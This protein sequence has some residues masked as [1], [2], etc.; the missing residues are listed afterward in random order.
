MKKQTRHFHRRAFWL[1]LL[2]LSA[3]SSLRAEP[4]LRLIQPFENQTLPYVKQSFVFGSVLPATAT[5]TI[6]GIPV[7][8]YTNG[9]FCVM[10][11]FQEGRFKIEA[12]A[13][14]G[15]S[16]TTVTR[17]VVVDGSA[18]PYP[19]DYDRIEPLYPKTRVVVRAG[20][21]IEVAFQAAPGGTA[22]FRFK[23]GDEFMPME[24][25][26]GRMPG[27]YKGSYTVRPDDKFEN[28][29]VVFLLKRRDGKKISGKLGANIILQRRRTPR[30]VELKED[31]I[32]LTGPESDYGYNLFAAPG[33]RLEVTGERGDFLRVGIGEENQG[34]IKKSVAIEMPSGAIL[35]RSVSRNMKINPGDGSTILE[36]P[37]Q[38]RHLYRVEQMIH[39]HTIK[40]T[41]F[42]VI[43]D[44]D[45]IR[46]RTPDSVI[47]EV[48][49]YQTEPTTCVIEIRTDQ[50]HPWGYDVRYEG[51]TLF[52]EVRHRPVLSNKNQPLKGMRIAIDAGHS[53]ESYGTIGPWGNTEASI[54]LTV[55]KVVKQELEKRG[56]EVIMPQDGTKEISL[57]ERVNFAWR[58]KAQL[59]IS[60]HCDACPE[61]QDPREVQGYSIHYYHPQSHALAKALHQFYG[62]KSGFRDQGLWR[63]NL[64]VCRAPQ[65]PAL[66]MEQGFLILP[67]YE[68]T[69]LTPKHAMNV[70]ESIIKAITRFMDENPK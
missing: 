18:S 58:Q 38:F 17:N 6:N 8:P 44:S 7:K 48:L 70:A 37:L 1:G 30:V 46:Y 9:G 12:V 53:R 67:E 62:V 20:D 14:D 23:S 51:T 34:W 43:A 55:A 19:S 45:R 22:Q 39:P 33:T 2:C 50:D 21:V 4:F 24:E 31:S 60:L 52:L 42:G 3:V 26:S 65:M 36:I 63:S 68:E 54:N 15:T 47:N 16:T 66:L 27:T 32:L 35:P 40:L 10:I 61:G 64:A 13:F 29:D 25:V 28:D 57:Q 59:F 11:P 69:M 5:L 49:W 56:A 41:L